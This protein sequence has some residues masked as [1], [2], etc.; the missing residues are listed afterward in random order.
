MIRVVH[1]TK[2]YGSFA[3]LDDVS[4][5]IPAGSLTAL[6]GPS[7][8]GKST[9]LRA[10]AGLEGLDSG[11]IVIAGADGSGKAGITLIADSTVGERAV[12]FGAGHIARALTPLLRTIGFRPVVVDDRPG[13]A[14]AEHFMMAG[15]AR[16]FGDEEAR[17]Q[18]LAR[19]VDVSNAAQ[20][21]QL[22]SGLTAI[23]ATKAS[24]GR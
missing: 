1:A 20:M 12:I 14:T 2:F 13:F 7:G 18:V 19:K 17:A 4:L 5:D 11:S 8:S 16:L 9:L 3:A 24:N 15:K 10:I 21:E 23:T 22:R 6:L